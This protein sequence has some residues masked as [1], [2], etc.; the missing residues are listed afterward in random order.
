MENTDAA[1]LPGTVGILHSRSNSG[2]GPGVGPSL[3]E[4]CRRFCLCGQRLARPL[5]GQRLPDFSG[6][7]PAT[8]GRA[9][10]S[11]PPVRRL[12]VIR[13]VL[14]DAISTPARPCAFLIDLFRK[15]GLSDLDAMSRVFMDYPAGEIE[16]CLFRRPSRPH[17]RRPYLSAH[18]GRLGCGRRLSGHHS[19]GLPARPPQP[20]SLPENTAAE[21]LPAV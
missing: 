15:E 18:D 5:S 16:A 14:P 13:P 7:R 17:H 20:F 21:I 12:P 3:F 1:A 9:A 10:A 8:M 4:P 6:R 11:P 19:H 2:G